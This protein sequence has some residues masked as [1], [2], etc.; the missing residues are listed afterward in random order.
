MLPL[1]DGDLSGIRLAISGSESEGS[2]PEA[3]GRT[4]I[5]LRQAVAASGLMAAT[6]GA[7]SSS[8][9]QRVGLTPEVCHA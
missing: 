3:A 7:L 8:L 1:L 9:D 6:G 5:S 2:L 4:S